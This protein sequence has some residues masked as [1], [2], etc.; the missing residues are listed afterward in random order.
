MT[1]AAP[2]KTAKFYPESILAI[3]SEHIKKLYKEGFDRTAS[4]ESF[5]DFQSGLTIRQRQWLDF[6]DNSSRKDIIH[7]T[8][9]GDDAY[10]QVLPYVTVRNDSGLLLPYLRGAAVGEARLAGNASVGFG[11]H[12]DLC[13]VVHH[14]STI[15]FMAT[16]RLNI[17]RELEEELLVF[18]PGSD[19]PEDADV[20]VMSAGELRFNGVIND[21]SDD[22]GRLHLGFSFDFVLKPGYSAR[23]REEELRTLPWQSG[24]ELSSMPG[25]KVENW[26]NLYLAD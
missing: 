1:Q 9:V 12:V 2:V 15:D 14:N 3:S 6:S 18:V 24:S 21:H 13:D 20:P 22:V 26:S 23:S 11:G 7:T 4:V 17:Q 10:R 5:A 16:V 25:V 19:L 8:K